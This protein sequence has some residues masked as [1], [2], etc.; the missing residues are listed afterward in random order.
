MRF[1][2]SNTLYFLFFFILNFILKILFLEHNPF[3][4]D[5]IISVGITQ[6]DFGH[7]KHDAEWDN[8]PPFYYYCLWVWLKIFPITEFYS[9]LMS[10]LFTSTAVSLAFILIRKKL[11]IFTA[12]LTCLFLSLSN[13]ILF[14]AHD[15]R[16]YSLILL[17]GV[18]STLLF[19][20]FLEKPSYFNLF[21]LALTNFLILYSHYI[22]ALIIV[23]QYL[24]ILFVEKRQFLKLYV[25]QNLFIIGFVLL[26]F[27]KK[28]FK[29]IFNFNINGDFWLKPATF[30]DFLYSIN[31]LFFTYNLFVLTF[32]LSIFGFYFV[33]KKKRNENIKFL[34][35]CFIIG[36]F[37]IL[38]LYVLGS[39]K[40]VYL[41]R[42]LIFTIPFVIIFNIYCIS[43]I[44]KVGAYISALIIIPLIININLCPLKGMDYKPVA[45]IIKQQNYKNE[46]CILINTSDNL[47]LFYYYYDYTNFVN[48]RKHDSLI[49]KEKIFGINDTN[50]FNDLNIQNYKLI[51]LVQSF[52]KKNGNGE[53]I[54][55][56]FLKQYYNQIFYTN[57]FMATEFSIFKKI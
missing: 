16:A 17:L 22:A 12:I 57:T 1:L 53:D 8:N 2:N 52:N 6:K 49:L 40:A 25:Y 19:F 39:F 30:D 50:Q 13:I 4:Y 9:R 32:L 48:V 55:R 15:A 5:E 24:F 41:D 42:Y 11:N 31:Q 45:T 7:V 51:Y 46:S 35:Y 44:K 3:S 36:Y 20:K 10:V 34:I 27:T 26:R 37:S 38:I 18:V 28:Q 56:K 29:L 23:G 14:Y 54:I 43:K 47:N 33:L 21:F